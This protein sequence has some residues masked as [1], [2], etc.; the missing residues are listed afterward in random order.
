ML[1]GHRSLKIIVTLR[2]TGA[3]PMTFVHAPFHCHCSLAQMICTLAVHVWCCQKGL[4]Q[5]GFSDSCHAHHSAI[6]EGFH[7]AHCAS[8]VRTITRYIPDD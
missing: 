3:T 1:L 4:D 5:P 8:V 2:K 6:D 7:I